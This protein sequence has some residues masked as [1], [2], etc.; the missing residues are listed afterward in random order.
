MQARAMDNLRFIR[1][2]ME[3]AV[4]FTAVSGWGQVVLGITAIVT[5]I[6]ASRQSLPA[7]KQVKAHL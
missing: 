7:L 5:A 4:T 6:V 3:S 2:V 1:G